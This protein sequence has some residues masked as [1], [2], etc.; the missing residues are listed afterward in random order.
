MC[1][2][3]NGKVFYCGA[4]MKILSKIFGGNVE[5]VMGSSA[6]ELENAFSKILL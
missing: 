3:K 5:R 2:D 6:K 1:E 4:N